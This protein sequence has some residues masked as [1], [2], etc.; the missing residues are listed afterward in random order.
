MGRSQRSPTFLIIGMACAAAIVAVIVLVG[1]VTD[2][3]LKGRDGLRELLATARDT[4]AATKEAAAAA[5][6]GAASL[7]Q[8][9]DRLAALEA[10]LASSKRAAIALNLDVDTTCGD[11]ECEAT[12]KA[13]CARIGYP[14]GVT[15]RFTGGPRPALHSLVCF[16]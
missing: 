13:V 8:M 1:D 3:G 14:N 16:D 9:S 11:P 4:N 2:S 10:A 6:S 5:R 15:S 12:A 7:R